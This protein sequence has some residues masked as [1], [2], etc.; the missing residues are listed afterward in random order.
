MLRTIALAAFAI[1]MSSGAATAHIEGGLAGGFGSGFAHP[2]LGADHIAAMVAVGLWGAFL[3]APAI[4]LLPIAFPLMMAL[5]G[6][7]GIIGVPLPGVEIGIAVSALVLGLMVALAVKPHLAVAAVMV[8]A[9]AI[10]HGYAHGAE[11]PDGGNAVAYSAGFVIATGVLH[12]CGIA[13]GLLTRWPAGVT[14]V[15]LTGSAIAIAGLI[16]LGKLI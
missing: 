1:A 15:R 2:I 11:L 14:A 13:I 6:I 16:F 4:W 5:G 8:G 9:F 7:L 12:L 10:F 3:G